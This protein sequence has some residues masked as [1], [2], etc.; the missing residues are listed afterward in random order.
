MYL[1]NTRFVLL[2]G[3]VWPKLW[4]VPFGRDRDVRGDLE[5]DAIAF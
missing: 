3:S 2:L 1:I 4:A 5:A